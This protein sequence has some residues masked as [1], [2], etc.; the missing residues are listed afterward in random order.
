[1]D[2]SRTAGDLIGAA[3][4]QLLH[5]GDPGFAEAGVA[6]R[7]PVQDS[8][9]PRHGFGTQQVLRLRPRRLHGFAQGLFASFDALAGPPLRVRVLEHLREH[10]V[11]A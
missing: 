10:E 3:V 7:Q 9:P 11:P 4:E 6:D 2:D 1:M 5:R 8:P